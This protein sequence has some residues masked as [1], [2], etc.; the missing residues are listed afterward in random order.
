MYKERQGFSARK[1]LH[2]IYV[3]IW[4]SQSLIAISPMYQHAELH[5]VNVQVAEILETEAEDNVFKKIHKD[6]HQTLKAFKLW[7]YMFLQIVWSIY[8]IKNRRVTCACQLICVFH[9]SWILSD[10]S[11]SPDNLD[12]A[13]LF[14]HNKGHTEVYQQKVLFALNIWK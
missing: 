4:T 14:R 12:D 1:Y 13:S 11:T 2:T 7:G 10:P 5:M 8:K 6:S 3:M 9:K